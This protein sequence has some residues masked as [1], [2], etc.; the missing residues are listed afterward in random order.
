M[1]RRLM[2]DD[3][4]GLGQPLKDNKMIELSYH[5]LLEPRPQTHPPVWCNS[6]HSL[7]FILIQS[8]AVQAFQSLLAHTLSDLLIHPPISLLPTGTSSLL[9]HF[10]SSLSLLTHPLPC[11]V[12]LL[13]LRSLEDRESGLILHHR[14]VACS[15]QTTPSFTCSLPDD[16]MVSLMRCLDES[17][18]LCSLL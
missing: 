9:S 14:G 1:D 6:H 15:Y 16:N 4:R 3:Y 12:H 10:S 11:G 5:L 2:Q 8:G 18:T 17:L 7:L 13:N